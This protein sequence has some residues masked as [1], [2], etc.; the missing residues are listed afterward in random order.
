MSL[1]IW[2]HSLIRN[3]GT[4]VYRFSN[5]IK[6]SQNHSHS[7]QQDSTVLFPK[8]RPSNLKSEN[9]SQEFSL[10]CKHFIEYHFLSFVAT[11]QSITIL[12]TGRTTASFSSFSHRRNVF[13]T[14]GSD[15]RQRACSRSKNSATNQH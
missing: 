9:S 5:Q 14:M 2:F 7:H 10:L 15:F 1:R 8:N 13:M 6:K 3:F 12:G 4:R 11:T